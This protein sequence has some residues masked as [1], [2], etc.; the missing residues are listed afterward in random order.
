M[1]LPHWMGG[2]LT[3]DWRI[4]GK[5]GL[6]FTC[7]DE[8]LENYTYV[9]IYIYIYIYLI[10]FFFFLRGDGQR[11][12]SAQAALRL[13]QAAALLYHTQRQR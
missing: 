10:F 6:S 5:N 3:L 8:G 4:L 1:E 9:S 7:V 11:L 2:S 13:F 12:S